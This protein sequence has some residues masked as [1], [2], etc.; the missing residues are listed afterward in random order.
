MSGRFSTISHFWHEI[1]H[2]TPSCKGSYRA[3]NSSELSFMVKNGCEV[4]TPTIATMGKVEW[5]WREQFWHVSKLTV[6]PAYSLTGWCIINLELFRCQ[7]KAKLLAIL[8]NNKSLFLYHSFFHAFQQGG[9]EW[10]FI[11]LYGS[12]HC[13]TWTLIPFPTFTVTLYLPLQ[14]N[15]CKYWLAI[16]LEEGNLE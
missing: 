2:M 7:Q 13:V 8:I 5:G 14:I 11:F 12:Y 16:F 4:P 9:P 15:P 6:I 10:P 3:T 1:G